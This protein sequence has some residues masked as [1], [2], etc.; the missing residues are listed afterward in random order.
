LKTRAPRGDV[1]VARRIVAG[2]ERLQTYL[3]YNP[4]YP[5]LRWGAAS[6][7]AAWHGVHPGSPSL[8]QVACR[9][10]IVR[11]IVNAPTAAGH[12]T[13]SQ[14]CQPTT[15]HHGAR[16]TVG[17]R[18]QY[19]EE[20]P[21]ERPS[22]EDDSISSG[23]GV[24]AV[25]S[26]QGLAA[27]LVGGRGRVVRVVRRRLASRPSPSEDRLPLASPATRST[28]RLSPP[29]PRHSARVHVSIA[30]TCFWGGTDG[31]GGASE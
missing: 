6:W 30:S 20:L 21:G 18:S 11:P 19:V 25:A 29:P 13:A 27:A 24:F 16:R 31:G 10:I 4:C 26:C 14:P 1:I 22:L 5:L 2:P 23:I 9:Y 3:Q 17:Q 15:S 28:L 8:L 7:S 12:T